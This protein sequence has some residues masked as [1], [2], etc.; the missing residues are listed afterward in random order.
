MF[1]GMR[2]RSIEDRITGIEERLRKQECPHP[3]R[4]RYITGTTWKESAFCWVQEC[5][6]CGKRFKY[7]TDETEYLEAKQKLMSDIMAADSERLVEL[8]G[9]S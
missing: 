1:D 7:Y 3:I 5:S 9:R 4:R 8:R 6:N 2:F